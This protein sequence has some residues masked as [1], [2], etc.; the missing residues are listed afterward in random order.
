MP[1]PR[2]DTSHLVE[3]PEGIDL[4]AQVAGPVPRALAYAIDLAART[5]LFILLSIG[6]AFVGEVGL[7]L[8]LLIGFGLEWFYP[9]LFEIYANGQTP[10]KKQLGLAVVGEDLGPLDWSRSI[11]RNLL[12]VADFLPAGYFAGLVSMVSNG[13]FQRLGDLAAG[14]IV[15]HRPV[16]SPAPELPAAPACAPPLRLEIEEQ[17]AVVAL[18]QR[19]RRL[20]LDRQRELA[21]ILGPELHAEGD[22]ALLRLHGMARW[23]MG[24]R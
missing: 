15:I 6:F 12:R 23:L 19:H 21:D 17:L 16:A 18:A 2:L 5:V 22:A 11:L 9:V 20:S 3:T 14:T 7:G 10:G 1:E 8:L 24:E 13:R 4:Q